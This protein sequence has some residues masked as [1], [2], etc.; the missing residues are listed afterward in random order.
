[1]VNKVRSDL[2]ILARING[3]KAAG[4]LRRKV[5]GGGCG[6]KSEQFILSLKRRRL[7]PLFAK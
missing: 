2:Q 5:I 4:E 6:E 1:M 3:K 7:V